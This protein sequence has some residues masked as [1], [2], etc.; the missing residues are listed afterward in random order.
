MLINNK[1]KQY[2]EEEILP[3]YN[4]NDKGHGIDHIMYVIDRSLKF[5]KMVD[6]INLDMIYVVASYHDIGHSIDAKN[7]EQVSAKILLEDINLRKYFSEDEI[8]IMQEAVEDH[9]SN[10]E[11][12]PRSIY[13]K[14]VSSADRNTIV[15][16]VF[17]RT[18]EYRKKHYANMSLKEIMDG[19]YQHVLEKFGEKGYAV[20]KM[21]FEDLDYKKF[22]EDLKYFIKNRDEFDKEFIRINKLEKEIIKS[23]IENYIPYNEQEESDKKQM[24]EFIESNDDVLTRNNI[25]GHFTASSFVVNEDL[26]KT[27]LIKHN[28]LGGYIFPGGHADGEYDLLSVAIREV[29]EETGLEVEEYLPEIFSICSAP[30]KGHIKNGGY[31]SSHNHYDLLY[32]CVA[33]NED[34]DKIR[35]LETENSDIKW[36]DLDDCYNNDVVDWVRPINKKIVEKVKRLK[37]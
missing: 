23:Q 28:I 4:Q 8:K 32:L 26:D 10:L 34:M 36:V 27:L 24:L 20:D 11:Y 21:F 31:V 30:V 1:L 5:A 29:L 13:G 19:S 15:E 37:R 16:V 22:L 18:Y 35:I 9:R 12:E 6:D 3:R 17:K 2:I 33:K 7:H 25:F 14:I